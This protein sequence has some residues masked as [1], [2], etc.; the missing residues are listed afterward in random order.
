[1]HLLSRLTFDISFENASQFGI[2][3]NCKA[4]CICYH[5][6]DYQRSYI[7]LLLHDNHRKD[8]K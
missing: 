5:N 2:F 3:F 4:A 7:V 1:M 6:N 8:Q